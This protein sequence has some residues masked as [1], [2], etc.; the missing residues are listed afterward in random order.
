MVDQD[1]S[2]LREALEKARNNSN[3][4]QERVAK[5]EIEIGTHEES[6]KESENDLPE[7]LRSERILDEK[8]ANESKKLDLMEK[9]LRD[10]EE[11]NSKA[12]ERFSS[13]Q[14]A[15]KG[16]EEGMAR[17]ESVLRQKK[18][19]FEDGLKSA[20]FDGPE[21]YNSVKRARSRIKALEREIQ[22]FDANLKFAIQ[23]RDR[24]ARVCKD[25]EEPQMESLEALAKEAT[26]ELETAI[27]RSAEVSEK[28]KSLEK[29][30]ETHEKISSDM[31]LVED[32]FQIMGGIADIA[33]GANPERITF[34]RFVLSELLE[35]VAIAATQRLNMMSGGRYRL[36]RAASPSDKRTA[37][38]LDFEVHDEYTGVA[39]PARSLSGGETF[40]ASLAL[41]LG[42]S[43]V[44]SEYTG[45]IR[46]DTIFIDEGF[47][48][49]DPEALDLAVKALYDLR[50]GGRIVGI[51]SHV[52][53]LRERIPSRIEVKTT[54]RGSSA[55]VIA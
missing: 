38:G 37:G 8:I 2:D 44:T 13:A 43:D 41:A 10:S 14:A 16:E 51:I 36:Q 3:S 12:R 45:G 32:R 4:A 30:L 24:A 19:I 46:L 5:I 49:L 15:L 25:L 1:I 22:E 53:E 28:L 23:R 29:D 42:L 40:L 17:A 31:A 21:E 9:E 50:A 7:D 55:S 35:E 11:W 18:E 27:K 6:L 39:R 52:P 20:G 47:G 33:N 26:R 48:G 34:H 54:R